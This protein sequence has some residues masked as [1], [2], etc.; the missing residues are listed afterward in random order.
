MKSET[1]QGQQARRSYM[2][3]EFTRR[4]FVRAGLTAL[5]VPA[6]TGCEEIDPVTF[7]AFG[8]SRLTVSPHAPT[9][10]APPGAS[11]LGIG[12]ARDGI[13]Y[14]PSTYDPATPAPLFVALHGATGSGD[15]WNGFFDRCEELGMVML[16]PDSRNY[17]WD[18]VLG[19]FRDDPAFLDQ[20]LN[21]TFDRCS[22]DPQRV[23]LAGF[24]DG[25]SYALS[26][27]PSNGDLFTHLIAFSPGFARQAQPIVGSPRVFISHGRSDQILPVRGSRN[28][29]VPLFQSSGYDVT[30]EEFDGRHEM[31]DYIRT[32]AMEWFLG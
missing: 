21:H 10:P 19:A 15:N 24:S 17:T 8:D 9:L 25:A 4:S 3:R 27:G 28:E 11:V 32:L 6:L 12:G 31:P 30:Y 2:E 22:I 26:L 1:I 13:L 23:A 29:I 16:A 18:R 5:F 14:V 7:N 20:A